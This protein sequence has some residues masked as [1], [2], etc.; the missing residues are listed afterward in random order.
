VGGILDLS[1][2]CL[3]AGGGTGYGAKMTWEELLYL[4]KKAGT[5]TIGGGVGEGAELL[6]VRAEMEKEKALQK[7]TGKA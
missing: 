2:K 7:G 5:V 4:K 6:G 3:T 1:E